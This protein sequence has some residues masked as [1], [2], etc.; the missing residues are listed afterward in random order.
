[1]TDD[2]EQNLLC[3]LASAGD[4]TAL[5]AMFE[6]Y[7]RRLQQSLRLRMDTRLKGRIDPADVLQDAFIDACKRLPEYVAAPNVS[8]FLWVR[9]LTMQRLV[10]LH[11]KHLGARMRSAGVE[12]SMHSGNFQHASSVTL[13]R[14]LIDA[15]TTPGTRMV[16][17]ETKRRVREAVTSLDPIDREVLVMRHFEMLNNGE[18][19]EVLGLS[20]AAASNRYV[21][22]LTRLERV[23]HRVHQ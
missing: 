20:K 18:V 13:T 16:A 17:L 11:R 7:R 14:L 21:R 23:L 1:M 15:G 5:A 10:D 4:A 19:A 22:A 3:R 8:M 2:T 12:V 9:S 6:H